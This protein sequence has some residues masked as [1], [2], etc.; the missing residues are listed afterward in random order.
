MISIEDVLNVA[1]YIKMTGLTE[2]Q[3]AFCMV[4]FEDTAESDPSGNQSLWIEQLL[5]ECENDISPKIVD[6]MITELFESLKNDYDFAEVTSGEWIKGQK[7]QTHDSNSNERT[8][9][10]VQTAIN[11]FLRWDEQDDGN[12]NQVGAY[13]VGDYWAIEEFDTVTYRGVD[14]PVRE[15]TVTIDGE[16][17]TIHSYIIAPTSLLAAT[18]YLVEGSYLDDTIYFYVEDANFYKT[19]QYIARNCLDEP[20]RICTYD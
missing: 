18:D 4:L 14:Y 15:L 20:M 13:L 17:D 1:N 6:D 12:I 11:Q 5:Y 19:Q 8:L 3:I 2:K 9:F 10:I 16:D 7:I